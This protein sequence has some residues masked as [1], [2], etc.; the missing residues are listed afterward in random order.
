[1]AQG[2]ITQEKAAFCK[3]AFM[4]RFNEW[5]LFYQFCQIFSVEI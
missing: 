2:Q 1:M 4:K 5:K 3:T